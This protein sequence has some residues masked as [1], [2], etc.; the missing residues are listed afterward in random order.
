MKE[1]N[2]AKQNKEVQDV[3]DRGVDDVLV[4]QSEVS[5]FV[6]AKFEDWKTQFRNISSLNN[7]EAILNSPVAMEQVEAVNQFLAEELLSDFETYAAL[8][9]SEVD[10]VSQ[11]SELNKKEFIIWSIEKHW[12]RKNF[13]HRSENIRELSDA[14]KETCGAL[15][16]VL[17]DQCDKISGK[18]SIDRTNFE[19]MDSDEGLAYRHMAFDEGYA[20]TEKYNLID[21][22]AKL[23]HKDTLQ[24]ILDFLAHN[25]DGYFTAKVAEILSNI[26]SHVAAKELLGRLKT[27][28]DGGLRNVYSRVLYHLECGQIKVEQEQVEYLFR[29]YN[30]KG[31]KNT[32]VVSAIR[33]T[34][35]GKLGLLDKSNVLIGYIE[36]G[37]FENEEVRE[38]Q[39]MEISNDLLSIT[40]GNFG[41]GTDEFEEQKQDFL[42]EY[43][44]EFY[45]KYVQAKFGI[46][47]NNL[48]LREQFW[49]FQFL[50]KHQEGGVVEQIAKYGHLYRENFLKSFIALESSDEMGGVILQLAA[51]FESDPLVGRHLFD[52]FAQFTG[53]IDAQAKEVV[54]TYQDIFY[55]KQV[56]EGSLKK[57]LLDRTVE[58]LS[59]VSD[60][61]ESGGMQ[62]NEVIKKIAEYVRTQFDV[63]KQTMEELAVVQGELNTLYSTVVSSL[64]PKDQVIMDQVGEEILA[65]ESVLEY[66][67]HQV[68]DKDKF[69][70]ERVQSWIQFYREMYVPSEETSNILVETLGEEGSKNLLEQERK[71]N[72][73]KVKQLERLLS[74]QRACEKKL[75]LLVYGKESAVLPRGFMEEVL[76]ENDREKETKEVEHALLYFPVG[77][78]KDLPSWE[79]VLAGEARA[80]HPIEMYSYLLW[81]HNQGQKVQLVV[82]DTVQVF[83]YDRKY[84][85]GKKE[86]REK[87]LE[88]GAHE[89]AFY[90]QAIAQLG[91]KNIEVVQY[92][93]VKKRS[94][95]F[96]SENKSKENYK[97]AGK[98]GFEYY[99]DLCAQFSALPL[100]Q[101][102]LAAVVQT[103][104]TDGAEDIRYG[105]DEIAF[106]LATPGAKVSHSNEAR[107]DVLAA[108]IQELERRAEAA[109]VD[110][111]TTL[112]HMKQDIRGLDE[113]ETQADEVKIAV[114]FQEVLDDMRN[115]LNEK[116]ASLQAQGKKKGDAESEYCNAAANVLKKIRS[117]KMEKEKVSRADKNAKK[118]LQGDKPKVD[119]SFVVPSVDSQSFGWRSAAHGK[120]EV[121]KFKEPYSTYFFSNNAELFATTDQ[122]V[123]VKEGNIGGKILTLEKKNQE[124]YARRVLAPLLKEY[125]K[126][127]NTAAPQYFMRVGKTKEDI[128]GEMKQCQ[129]LTDALQFVQ[130]YI[131]TSEIAVA[132]REGQASLAAA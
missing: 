123:G 74:L 21:Q 99:A 29:K 128:V 6:E 58:F 40:K 96:S 52:Q 75:D 17:L 15:I 43:H 37:D 46:P 1:Y 116:K 5:K 61:L 70:S 28:K 98:S 25:R 132:P 102:A 54:Q 12:L 18:G 19:Q 63:Q 120:Q 42:R 110:C 113:A 103:S 2:R 97:K 114:F 11:T 67:K 127:L 118:K 73:P 84:G 22:Y 104:A 68:R 72:E 71:E 51:H 83:N 64:S 79:K 105:L 24:F 53:F 38:A 49:I 35:D 91:L 45:Q 66:A 82:C 77:I 36:F 7:L 108:F 60:E 80:A 44:S 89:V 8:P 27:E 16:R 62:K 126:A 55:E 33:I 92:D 56:D 50:R 34:P 101:E 122:V 48:E 112:G 87:A 117:V 81:L 125:V 10:G 4:P 32:E 130:T 3:I 115:F 26:D 76:P 23:E 95:I 69:D 47:V 30:L 106:I 9:L 94:E 90:K 119:F 65:D 57:A 107:Y 13:S 14:K 78:S 124:E 41:K 20:Q 100:F 39:I 85:I 93:E 31:N 129:T 86:A 131:V 59:G 111:M 88:I 121:V 109:G